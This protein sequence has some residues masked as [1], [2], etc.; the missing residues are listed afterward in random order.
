MMSNSVVPNLI[1]IYP[2][3]LVA[4]HSYCYLS[5]GFVRPRARLAGTTGAFTGARREARAAGPVCVA[6]DLNSGRLDTR[7]QSGYCQSPPDGSG[8]SWLRRQSPSLVSFQ[9]RLAAVRRPGS[10]TGKLPLDIAI[11]R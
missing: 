7:Q 9:G 5:E 11:H 2:F 4:Y 6:K 1:L 8:R 10:A 3:V